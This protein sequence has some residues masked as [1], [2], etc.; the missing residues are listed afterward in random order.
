MDVVDISWDGKDS[1]GACRVS[2]SIVIVTAK[3]G[4]LLT[5]WGSPEGAKK[6]GKDLDAI[7]ESIKPL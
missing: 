6:Y 5:Y 3:K 7:A 4:L 1:E 2:L